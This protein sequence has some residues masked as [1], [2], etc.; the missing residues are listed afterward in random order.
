MEALLTGLNT[1]LYMMNRLKVYL[2]YLLD[3]PAAQSR[4]NFELVLIELHARILQFLAR[5]IRIYQK[6]TLSRAFDAF[7]KPEEIT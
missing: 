5:A 4:A 1:A 2:Q 7:W 6:S 3:V